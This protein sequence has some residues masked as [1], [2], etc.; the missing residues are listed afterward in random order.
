ML[1]AGQE[2]GR[3]TGL[4]ADQERVSGLGHPEDGLRQA[5]ETNTQR[6]YGTQAPR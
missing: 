2:S 3:G 6:L 5:G 1:L 4:G